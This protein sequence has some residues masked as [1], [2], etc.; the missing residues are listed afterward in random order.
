MTRSV[1]LR[2][3]WNSSVIS[4]SETMC[5]FPSLPLQI[6]SLFFPTHFCHGAQTIRCCILSLSFTIYFETFYFIRHK[7][8]YSIPTSNKHRSPD[9]LSVP[10]G[11]HLYQAVLE[12]DWFSIFDDKHRYTS[13]IGRVVTSGKIILSS[14]LF[15]FS[16]SID[17]AT[18]AHVNYLSTLDVILPQVQCY[19]MD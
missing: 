12:F 9:H 16:N 18:H 17:R 4:C 7:S 19:A 6:N 5:T 1:Y 15:I 11:F 2:T 3:R 14:F 10:N 13:G 8:A